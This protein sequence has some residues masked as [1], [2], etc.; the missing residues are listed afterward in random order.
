MIR[1]QFR[2]YRRNYHRSN[3]KCCPPGP[4]GPKGGGSIGGTGP[5][6]PIGPAST[7]TGIIGPTGPTGNTGP[8]GPT[9]PVGNTG[10]NGINATG[11][12]GPYSELIDTVYFSA[13]SYQ[14]RQDASGY[15]VAGS[16]GYPFWYS[17]NNYNTTNYT[18]NQGG[19]LFPGAG[20]GM[21]VYNIA[22]SGVAPGININPNLQ[23]WAFTL[24]EPFVYRMLLSE[25]VSCSA[26][27][28]QNVINAASNTVL[29]TWKGAT[30]PAIALPYKKCTIKKIGWSI[31]GNR[32]YGTGTV[33]ASGAPF[34]IS[35]NRP[36][37]SNGSDGQGIRIE[38]WKFCEGSIDPSNNNFIDSSG[39][40]FPNEFINI[41]PVNNPCGCGLLSSPIITSASSNT[42]GVKIKPILDPQSLTPRTISDD[43]VISVSIFLEDILI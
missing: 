15:T 34:D 36:I 21:S 5:T 28:P 37:W 43:C 25:G 20:G 35:G 11:D 39:N 13:Y 16:E 3:T 42:I 4:T 27:L 41:D 31:S 9:G 2:N 24:G 7:G 6:G 33:T 32:L 8:I 12:T 29:S 40:P 10:P 19:W 1:S 14:Y 38:I 17:L 26:A 30:P 22:V 18:I 23:Y